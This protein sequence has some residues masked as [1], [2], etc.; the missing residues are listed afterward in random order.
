M[1]QVCRDIQVASFYHWP[2]SIRL[3]HKTVLE[4]QR[5]LRWIRRFGLIGKLPQ[6]RNLVF[7]HHQAA[8]RSGFAGGGIDVHNRSAEP[9][10]FRRDL[11]MRGIEGQ[12]CFQHALDLA[13]EDA[14]VT[15][16]SR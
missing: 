13:P 14:A 12:R 3:R 4:H 9:N 11:E 8:N 7:L 6:R 2:L 1:K 16:P 15:R 10:I 5:P